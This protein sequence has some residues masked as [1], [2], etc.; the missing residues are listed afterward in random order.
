MLKFRTT[1][2]E[3]QWGYRFPPLKSLVVIK[4]EEFR[5]ASEKSN[6]FINLNLKSPYDLVKTT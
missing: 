3:L 4:I 6:N 5:K 1:A 2:S